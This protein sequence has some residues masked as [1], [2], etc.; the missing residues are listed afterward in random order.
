MELA[1]IVGLSPTAT[2]HRIRKLKESGV[3]RRIRADLDPALAGFPLKV[4][5]MITLARHTPK[6]ERAFTDALKAIPEIVAAD[7]IAGETDMVVVVAA[8]DVADLQRVLS[9]LS[10]H[11]AQRI[12]TLLHLE[13]IKP[14]S[15]LPLLSGPADR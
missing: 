10:L 5:V 4:Y 14:P 12:T 9:R 13:E 15:P 2:L 8:R 6:A 11:G 1:R 3:I 7:V